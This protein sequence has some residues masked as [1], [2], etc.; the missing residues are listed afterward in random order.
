MK[1]VNQLV[2]HNCQIF[3]SPMGFFA[4]RFYVGQNIATTWSTW[5][6]TPEPDFASQIKAWFNEVDTY[7]FSGG[8]SHKTGHYSQVCAFIR[9]DQLVL[10]FDSTQ[11]IMTISIFEFFVT[12]M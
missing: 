8:F 2:L 1:P 5:E 7:S 3:S 11:F 4:G 10:D 12:S 6:K 9:R